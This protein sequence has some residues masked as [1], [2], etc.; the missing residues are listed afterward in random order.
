[1][2]KDIIDGMEERQLIY[3]FVV[4]AARRLY[5]DPGIITFSYSSCGYGIKFIAEEGE[6]RRYSVYGCDE[7]E[8]CRSQ[9]PLFTGDLDEVVEYLE[10]EDNLDAV[11]KQIYKEVK[12]EDE[13]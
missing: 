2:K 7:D 4:K 9:K 12:E 1:M 5:A 8:N 3:Q 11:M 6:W 10:N 13:E